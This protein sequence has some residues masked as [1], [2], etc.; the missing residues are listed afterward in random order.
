MRYLFLIAA[1][2]AL[3]V[4]AQTLPTCG[5]AST[6]TPQPW[7]EARVSWTAPTTYA[8]GQAFPTGTV[9]TY[10][11][12]RRVG[13]TGTF[14]ALCTTQATSTA[15][16]SQPVGSVFYTATARI[17]AGVESTQ[18]APP[19]NKT[20]VDPAPSPPTGITVASTRMEP[21]E[22]TC[23]D[24][25]GVVIT[26]HRSAVEA[27]TSCTNKAIESLLGGTARQ[28]ATF[29]MRPSGYRFVAQR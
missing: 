14:G 12:Y 17:G 29:E 8:N 2:A 4:Y 5:P 10:T 6:A 16:A 25:S 19:G 26:N 13:A 15:L 7:N 24:S 11:V 18:G 1:L 22:W 28:S 3:P 27:Q 20:I 23:R 21:Y 9:L